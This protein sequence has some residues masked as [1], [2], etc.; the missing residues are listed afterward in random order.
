M[1]QYSSNFSQSNIRG[2]MQLEIRGTFFQAGLVKDMINASNWSTTR[3]YRDEQESAFQSRL[4]LG[5]SVDGQS[6]NELPVFILS[7]LK[8]QKYLLFSDFI[9]L[10]GVCSS[11]FLFSY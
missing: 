1:M 3:N 10:V 6:D 7:R 2:W 5:T 11:G 9:H 8:F 4:W